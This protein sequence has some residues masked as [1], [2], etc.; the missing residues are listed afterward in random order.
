[1]ASTDRKT[2]GV[3]V[4]AHAP[5]RWGVVVTWV[6]GCACSVSARRS[7]TAPTAPIVAPQPSP[8][9]PTFP[10]LPEP[11]RT[12]IFEQGT[13]RRVSDYTKQSRFLLSDSGAFALQYMSLLPG[14]EY[15]G[16]YAESNG[17]ITFEWDGGN[18]ANP[19]AATA[20]LKDGLL[21]VHYNFIMQLTDFE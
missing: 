1:Q 12:F 14:G 7:P 13:G 2:S 4:M 20:T 11:L 17:V 10:P 8:P 19:W 3:A 18:G 9:R 21:S 16:E 5:I 6:L 15:R